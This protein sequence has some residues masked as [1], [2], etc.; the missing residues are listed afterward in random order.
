[1]E[2]KGEEGIIALKCHYS[3]GR[4]WGKNV[5]NSS[6]QWHENSWKCWWCICDRCSCTIW[7]R[8]WNRHLREH[9]KFL[10]TASALHCIP[11]V[12][13]QSIGLF[14]ASRFDLPIIVTVNARFWLKW[15]WPSLQWQVHS[16]IYSQ[17]VLKA[18]HYRAILNSAPFSILPGEWRGWQHKLEVPRFFVHCI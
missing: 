7:T 8:A 18:K 17:V 4:G 3:L 10:P 13:L 6:K 1:M 5:T 16:S 15:V 14:C 11:V 9:K 12:W 2:M